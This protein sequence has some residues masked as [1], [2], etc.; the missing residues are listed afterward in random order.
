M[1]N[2]E[3][4]EH[5]VWGRGL[6]CVAF[7]AIFIRVAAVPGSVSAFY[8]VLFATAVA[9]PLCLWKRPRPPFLVMYARLG[10][11]FYIVELKGDSTPI[12][13]CGL[14]KREFLDDVDIGYALL[15]T[16]L[17]ERVRV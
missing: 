2:K 14:V 10:F 16:V 8:R 4:A 5:Y 7:S 15:P 13:I 11:G 12:G 1:V 3:T 9:V 17:G 6:S